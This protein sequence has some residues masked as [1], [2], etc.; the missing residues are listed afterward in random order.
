VEILSLV[1]LILLFLGIASW[2]LVPI[3][4]GSPGVPAFEKRIR[5]ALELAE[6]QPGEIVY[7]LGAGDGRVLLIAARDFGARALG[8][9][10]EPVHCAVAWIRLL[11]GGFLSQAAVHL[12]N[13]YHSDL[14][15]ADVVFVY[16]TLPQI[17]RLQ[18]YLAQ[19]L[20]PG[21][22]LVSLSADFPGWQPE[23]VDAGDLIFLYRM[24]P[25]PG[26]L[27]EYLKIQG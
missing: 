24:P 10:I 3:L 25:K 8:I 23:A 21:V 9:E 5:R 2:V 11:L 15:G 18:P 16:L 26:G 19:R 6:I 4:A 1:I 7:D 20:K 27:D 14:S 22:R 12:Q 17:K 13:F